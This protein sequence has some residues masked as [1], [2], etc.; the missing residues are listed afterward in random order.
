MG[1]TRPALEARVAK[2]AEE[3]EG[4]E[5]VEAVQEFGEQLDEDEREL[6]G[7]IL[8]ERA[9]ARTPAEATRDYPRWRMILPRRR[10]R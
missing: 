1:W 10:R 5:L 8:L 2:L 6:L 3:H 7:R 9:R 4:E